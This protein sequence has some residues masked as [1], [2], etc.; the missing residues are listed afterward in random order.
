MKFKDALIRPFQDLFSFLKKVSTIKNLKRF[1]SGLIT[2]LFSGSFVIV[3]IIVFANYVFSFNIIGETKLMIWF[4]FSLIW[5]CYC[6]QFFW[7][8]FDGF[9]VKRGNRYD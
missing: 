2:I 9:K 3:P 4:A 1:F 8:Y 5:I 7:Y 6:G